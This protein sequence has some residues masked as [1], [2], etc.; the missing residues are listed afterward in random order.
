[1]V[2]KPFMSAIL[3]IPP[4]NFLTCRKPDDFYILNQNT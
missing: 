2:V 3:F 1:M 4:R